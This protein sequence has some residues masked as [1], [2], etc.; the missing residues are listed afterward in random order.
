MLQCTATTYL[1]LKTFGIFIISVI[2]IQHFG[3]FFG[4]RVR[5]GL[6]EKLMTSVIS[7]SLGEPD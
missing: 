4:V 1:R 6:W 3:A 2:H 7:L 5:L